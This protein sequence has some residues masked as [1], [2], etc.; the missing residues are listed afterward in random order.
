MVNIKDTQFCVKNFKM[1]RKNKDK[2]INKTNIFNM[3][4][5]ISKK[6]NK[7]SKIG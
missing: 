4:Y 6:Q 5:L 1:K 7:T 2:S 3:F